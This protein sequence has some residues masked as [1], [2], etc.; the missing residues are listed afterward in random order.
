MHIVNVVINSAIFPFGNYRMVSDYSISF[1]F[2]SKMKIN[3]NNKTTVDSSPPSQ[4]NTYMPVIFET[5]EHVMSERKVK[6]YS[7]SIPLSLCQYT[8][9][10]HILYSIVQRGDRSTVSTGSGDDTRTIQTLYALYY[11]ICRTCTMK[12]IL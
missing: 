10:C 7:N 12:T 4:H 5:T 1:L 9:Y 6:K 8:E 3:N 2:S 11:I